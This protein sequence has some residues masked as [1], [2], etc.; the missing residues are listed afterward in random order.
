MLRVAKKRSKVAVKLSPEQLIMNYLQNTAGITNDTIF[1]ILSRTPEFLET[2]EDNPQREKM[3]KHHGVAF[4]KFNPLKKQ[5]L[6]EHIRSTRCQY[7]KETEEQDEIDEM[8]GEGD[9]IRLSDM[10]YTPVNRFSTGIPE[11]DILFGESKEFDEIGIP[12]GATSLLAGSPGVGKSRLMIKVAGYVTHPKHDNHEVLYF[13]GASEGSQD[14]FAQWANAMISHGGRKNVIWS[15]KVHIEDQLAAVRK[16]KPKLTVVDSLQMIPETNSNAGAKLVITTYKDL[17]R[18]LGT[19]VIFIGQLNQKEQIAG[20]RGL[21]H[22]VDTVMRA[23]K[24]PMGKDEF[25]VD[26]NEKNRF[27]STGNSVHFR[28]TDDNILVIDHGRRFQ[29]KTNGLPEGTRMV[30]RIR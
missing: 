16:Y 25:M 11:F 26:C 12:F 6:N 22:L 7:N 30:E 19:H 10:V 15:S 8:M 23:T 13:L 20:R 1:D 24:N 27:G 28:H 18:E 2:I 21:Q 29:E 9:E 14:Q 5:R 17:M 4:P 3:A